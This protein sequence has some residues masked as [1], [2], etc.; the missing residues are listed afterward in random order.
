MQQDLK[1]GEINDY[2]LRLS[3]KVS[4]LEP[5][6]LDENYKFTISGTII[7]QTDKSNQDGTFNREYRLEPII[8]ELLDKLGRAIKSKDPRSKSKLLRACL[9]RNW[10]ETPN[11][12]SDEE[13]YDLVL[14]YIIANSESLANKSL[15]EK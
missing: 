12:L 13:F 7:S 10:K 15:Q 11:D 4:L 9:Y 5:I 8:V 3:G 1:Q 14:N 2:V 6:E